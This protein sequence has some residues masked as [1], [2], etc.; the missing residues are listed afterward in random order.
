MAGGTYSDA[1]VC[2]SVLWLRHW[3]RTL[4]GRCFNVAGVQPR[5]NM[6]RWRRCRSTSLEDVHCAADDSV[7]VAVYGHTIG[8]FEQTASA[9][10]YTILFASVVVVRLVATYAVGRR[11]AATFTY[12]HHYRQP[13]SLLVFFMSAPARAY[14]RRR[15]SG[16]SLAT[17]SATVI[18]GCRRPKAFPQPWHI[19]A[20]RC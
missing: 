3:A 10:R 15:T 8:Y 19:H 16:S 7:D 9:S 1:R 14:R 20:L 5:I 2:V 6:R 17:M 18:G 4:Y 12:H 13:S 11:H